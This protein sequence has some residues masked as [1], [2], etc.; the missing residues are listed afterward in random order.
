MI[1]PRNF[2]FATGNVAPVDPL[3]Y[4]YPVVYI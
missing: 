4:N 3:G 1:Y 2:A